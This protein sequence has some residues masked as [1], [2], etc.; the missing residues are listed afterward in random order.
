MKLPLI[1][2]RDE[3]YTVVEYPS[4]AQ[5]QELARIMVRDKRISEDQ[6]Q[7]IA[8]QYNVEMGDPLEGAGADR[9][10]ADIIFEEKVPSGITGEDIAPRAVQE[11]TAV[12]MG[13]V[14]SQSSAQQG[15]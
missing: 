12:F 10:A 3:E 5:V 8:D 2:G 6:K 13:I 1:P 14:T 7:E 9:K 11:A 4:N 15:T